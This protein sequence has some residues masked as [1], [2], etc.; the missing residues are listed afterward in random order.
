MDP[1]YTWID[2]TTKP[3]DHMSMNDCYYEIDYP[4]DAF[5]NEF[6]QYPNY[7]FVKRNALDPKHQ[8]RLSKNKEEMKRKDLVTVGFYENRL[9]D[10]FCIRSNVDKVVLYAGPHPN[11][12]S[13]LSLSHGFWIL[14]DSNLPYG[15]SLW[16]II[17][18]DKK[19]YDKMKNMTMDQLTLSIYKM[20]FY[21]GTSNFLND[22]MIKIEP[23]VG[24][25]IING[26]VDWMEIPG[27]GDDSWKGLDYLDKEMESDSGIGIVLEGGIPTGRHTR[28]EMQQQ[29]EASL[30]R[31]KTPIENIADIV[32]QDAYTSMSWMAQLYS[33]PQIM[34]FSTPQQ[35]LDFEK[36]NDTQHQ[37]LY[38]DNP[39]DNI[40]ATFLPQLA[41]HLE[42]RKGMLQ[43]SKNSQFF[44]VG[45]GPLATKNLKWKGIFKT[46]PKSLVVTSEALERAGKTEMV[47]LLVP[48]FAQPPELML[49]PAKQLLDVHDE[50][51]E[52]W[53]PD[54]WLQLDKNGPQQQPLFVPQGGFP[55][56][57]P[58]Q[59]GGMPSNQKTMQGAASTG[60][61]AAP[62]VVPQRNLS[63]PSPIPAKQPISQ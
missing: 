34:E 27:P 52:D 57:P 17:R 35:L 41:L 48:M 8:E 54:A 39:G 43:E 1:R 58:Q 56:Q 38:Q 23:G 11:D 28:A 60:P 53:L 18:Q 47:N 20:F 2:E 31:L 32:D 36:E 51:P 26:K 10:L 49:K 42:D 16:E 7:K 25:Q 6:K 55:G 12:D 40:Q 46:V 61:M 9:K 3:Y 45:K 33:T 44:Q 63:G 22:G 19:L 5:I 14:R 59:P 62:R 29:K 4:Y 15:V 13:M 21:T 24:K 50:D 37:Q 30:M